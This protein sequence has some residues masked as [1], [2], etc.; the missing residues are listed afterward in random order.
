MSGRWEGGH[1]H[2]ACPARCDTAA[3]CDIPPRGPEV[4]R[5]A[6][7]AHCYRCGPRPVAEFARDRSKASGRKSICKSCD[8]AKSASYYAKNSARVIARVSAYK[9]SGGAVEDG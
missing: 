9:R 7:E 6:E 5:D 8:A 2:Q 3:Q 4:A 1:G